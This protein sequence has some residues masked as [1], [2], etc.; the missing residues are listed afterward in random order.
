MKILEMGLLILGGLLALVWAYGV[1]HYVNRGTPPTQMT[2][3][4]AMLFAV[5]VVA[6]W[7]LRISPF[8]LLW[9]FP[10]G[11]VLG[12]MSL[13]FPV[14]LLGIPGRLYGQV[15]CWGL[16]WTEVEKR[17]RRI[18]RFGELRRSGMT[19][20]AALQTVKEEAMN[21]PSTVGLPSNRN[22]YAA[23][24]AV[25]LGIADDIADAALLG[26]QQLEQAWLDPTGPLPNDERQQFSAQQQ[27]TLAQILLSFYLH[28]ADRIA[29]VECGR[30]GR[31]AFMDPMTQ[32]ACDRL[33]RAFYRDVNDARRAEIASGIQ[34]LQ[35]IESVVYAKCER[36]EAKDGEPREGTL[37]KALEK[38]IAPV[39]GDDS[40]L[41]SI[42]IVGGLVADSLVRLQLNQRISAARTP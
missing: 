38:K 31:D 5:T 37:L 42:L 9:A 15:C 2:V 21:G 1:R 11:V 19:P 22:A 33:T 26:L 32:R 39:I 3:N 7:L 25:V 8:H 30:E 14:S 29:F 13:V 16:N 12:T 41:W 27:W 40:G 4:T 17:R 10:V 35:E 18:E 24:G 6:V 36:L 20:E 23:P 28:I 34:G